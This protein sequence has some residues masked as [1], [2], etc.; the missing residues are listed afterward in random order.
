MWELEEM[1]EQELAG[2]KE[3]HT[4]YLRRTAC[5]LHQVTLGLMCFA[6][7]DPWENLLD[8]EWKF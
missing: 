8:S 7:F 3:T 5:L 4:A 6:F 2:I 1:D